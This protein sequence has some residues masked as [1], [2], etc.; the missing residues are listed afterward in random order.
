MTF[1]LSF[2]IPGEPHAAQQFSNA[3]RGCRRPQFPGQLLQLEEVVDGE[4]VETEDLPGHDQVPQVRAGETPASVAAA[5]LV[6]RPEIFSISRIPQVHP[7]RG[8]Q[9]RGVAR[10]ARR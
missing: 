5:G 2:D 3:P 8:Y 1:S 7:S 10:N 4:E 9:S 6:K